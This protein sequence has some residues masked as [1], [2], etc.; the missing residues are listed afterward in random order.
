MTD[1]ITRNPRTAFRRYD[2]VTLVITPDDRRV[3]RLN[4]TGSFLWDKVGETGMTLQA[5]A[6]AMEQEYDAPLPRIKTDLALFVR[7]LVEKDI[8]IIGKP[9]E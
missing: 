9:R 5:L 7:E 1:L 4:P 2:G 8:L 6:Q 3:H